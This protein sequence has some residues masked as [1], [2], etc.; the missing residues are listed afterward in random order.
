MALPTTPPLPGR[1]PSE[2]S[3][4]DLAGVRLGNIQCITDDLMSR[5]ED[6]E[7]NVLGVL[8]NLLDKARNTQQFWCRIEVTPITDPSSSVPW[9]RFN[10]SYADHLLGIMEVTA[11][12]LNVYF[13]ATESKCTFSFGNSTFYDDQPFTDLLYSEWATAFIARRFKTWLL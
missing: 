10:T 2:K 12:V 7:N 13:Q 1:F 6:A 5:H 9:Y 11:E 3:A 8:L 4:L